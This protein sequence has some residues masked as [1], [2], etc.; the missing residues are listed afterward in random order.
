MEFPH[1]EAGF[2]KRISALRLVNRAVQP[3]VTC[4]LMD[5]MNH[6]YA[7]GLPYRTRS[8]RSLLKTLR[9]VIPSIRAA[10]D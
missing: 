6:R 3:P 2:R 9:G 10:R 1:S 8:F 5:W 4:S 7:I